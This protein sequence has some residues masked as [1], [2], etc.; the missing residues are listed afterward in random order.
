[1]NDIEKIAFLIDPDDPSYF[2][3]KKLAKLKLEG[4]S[5]EGAH[6]PDKGTKFDELEVDD[7]FT[8]GSGPESKGEPKD[9]SD[10]EADPGDGAPAKPKKSSVKAPKGH[11][12]VGGDHKPKTKPGKASTVKKNVTEGLFD[13][14]DEM[15]RQMMKPDSQAKP[16]GRRLRVPPSENSADTFVSDGELNFDDE[17]AWL[18]KQE[19]KHPELRGYDDTR[20]EYGLDDDDEYHDTGDILDPSETE[21]PGSDIALGDYMDEEPDESDEY[22]WLDDM[23]ESRKREM[24][25]ISEALCGTCGS[26]RKDDPNE[27]PEEAAGFECD[28]AS[29]ECDDQEEWEARRRMAMLKRGDTAEFECD[30]AGVAAFNDDMAP[31]PKPCPVCGHETKPFR[32]TVRCPSCEWFED[33]PD[34]APPASVRFPDLR[35]GGL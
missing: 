26:F 16:Q 32:G 3:E 2:D 30:S 13:S 21:D 11:K 35:D 25:I 5:K 34:D 14:D 28:M 20:A 22:D 10:A 15:L 23:L 6:R 31:P 33:L 18:A 12:Y 27:T 4:K 17:D 1:M 7:E 8:D 24:K 19:K 9:G 29:F